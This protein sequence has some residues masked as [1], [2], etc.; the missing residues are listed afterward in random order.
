VA[1]DVGGPLFLLSTQGR[2]T[3][4]TT[5]TPFR[6]AYTYMFPNGSALWVVGTRD[7]TWE[8]LGYPTP[9]G[10]SGYDFSALGAYV[11]STTLTSPTARGVLSASSWRVPHP[12]TRH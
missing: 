6:H 9:A 3:G 10:S 8:S 1:L 2:W 12:C 5:L 4:Q 7:T 11:Q